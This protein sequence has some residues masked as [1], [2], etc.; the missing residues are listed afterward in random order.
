MFKLLPIRPRE[1]T[2]FMEQF[3]TLLSNNV[4]LHLAMRALYKDNA[5]LFFS[6]VIKDLTRQVE[7]GATLADAMER[8]T[9][10]FDRS[11]INLIRAGTNSGELDQALMQAADYLR[12]RDETRRTIK[13]MVVYPSLLIL[14]LLL[15][16]S[17]IFILGVP[18][19]KGFYQ[20]MHVKIPEETQRLFDF[21]DA[22]QNFD[23]S[24]AE[25]LLPLLMTLLIVSFTPVG[26]PFWSMIMSRLPGIARLIRYSLLERFCRTL[27]VQLD[28]DVP[29]T[30]AAQQA[31]EATGNEWFIQ[32]VN[33]SLLEIK[34]G[35]SLFEAFNRRK[36]AFDEVFLQ[37]LD[38]GETSGNLLDPL[39]SATLYY[40][41]AARHLSQMIY[42]FAKPILIMLVAAMIGYVLF[43]LVNPIMSID[44]NRGYDLPD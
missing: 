41:R 7:M 30:T 15:F 26:R 16:V 12:K 38:A 18:K 35:S 1:I 10:L 39:R 42:E 8:H 28:N 37:L 24:I 32:A 22:I 34:Q 40:E 31:A 14:L 27:V 33:A 23:L 43:N 3:A 9:S 19:L 13:Q 20:K 17:G 29:I 2:T 21:A 4:H 6:M 5:N 11:I 36:Y 44:I 25:A